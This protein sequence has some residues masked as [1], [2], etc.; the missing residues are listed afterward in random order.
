MLSVHSDTEEWQLAEYL[1]FNHINQS[2]TTKKLRLLH[3]NQLLYLTELSLSGG[4]R[5]FS[6]E[7]FRNC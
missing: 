1:E 5:I 4:A 2:I 3:E 6:Y 7:Y